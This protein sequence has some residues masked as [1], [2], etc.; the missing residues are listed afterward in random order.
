MYL[1]QWG[2]AGISILETTSV[3]R[4]KGNC[5]GGCVESF[6]ISDGFCTCTVL[7]LLAPA[8]RHKPLRILSDGEQ[9]ISFVNP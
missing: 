8:I 4:Q 6:L 3:S 7:G 2:R 1:H 5:V 9:P